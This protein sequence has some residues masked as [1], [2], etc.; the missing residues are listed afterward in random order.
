MKSLYVKCEA[1]ESIQGLYQPFAILNGQPLYLCKTDFTTKIFFDGVWKLSHLDKIWTGNGITPVGNYTPDIES[2]AEGVPFAGEIGFLPEKIFVS[3]TIGEV[4]KGVYTLIDVEQPLYKKNG[5]TKDDYQ[6]IKFSPEANEYRIIRVVY[7][8]EHVLCRKES[9][10]WDGVLGDYQSLGTA[11]VEEYKLYMDARDPFSTIYYALWDLL[12]SNEEFCSRVAPGNRIKFLGENI[13]PLKENT[14]TADYPEVR[15]IS[16]STAPHLLHTSS[17]TTF[18][19]K[20][21]IQIITNDKRLD[22]MLYP[23]EWLVYIILVRGIQNLLNL[24]WRDKTFVLNV[25]AE[26]CTD[27]YVAPADLRP[28]IG[29]WVSVINLDFNLSLKTSEI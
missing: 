26:S 8:E 7:E 3:G 17:S 21:Q 22:A 14:L 9:N 12:E 2:G 24:K 18:S 27:S 23:L 5:G 6:I 4:A 20:F 13:N 10:Y 19:K 29:G 1:F 11:T 25:S 15:I 16:L 28:A